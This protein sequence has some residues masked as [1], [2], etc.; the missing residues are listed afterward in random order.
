[1]NGG[2]YLTKVVNLVVADE[3]VTHIR[4]SFEQ[5]HIIAATIRSSSHFGLGRIKIVL[6]PIP[7]SRR[8]YLIRPMEST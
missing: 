1:M 7:A 4:G 6:L 2:T 3:R 5:A 8:I